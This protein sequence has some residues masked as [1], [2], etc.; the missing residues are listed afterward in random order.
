MIQK[1]IISIIIP[2]FNGEKYIKGCLDSVLRSGFKNF[3]IIIIND[4]STD[5]SGEILKEY[6]NHPKIK[7][8]SFQ[9]NFGPAKARNSGAEKAKGKYLIFLDID[10]EI[11]T[12]CLRAVVRAFEQN[13]KMGAL[14]AKII[15]GRGNKI[16]AAGHF[17]TFF[18]FPYEIGGGEKEKNHNE[19]RLI[20]GARSAAMAVRKK[21]F[22]K[23]GGF[24]EDYFI[25]GEDTD[26]SWRVW[27]VGYQIYYLPQAKVYHFT[28]SSLTPKTEYRI[29]Y[30]GSKN[31]TLNLLK[32][33]PLTLLIWIL[34]LHVLAWTLL[35]LKLLFQGRSKL[36]VSIYQGVWWNLV[37][38]QETVK[39]RRRV[40]SERSPHP[41]YPK[42]I[43]GRP[44][45]KQLFLKGRRWFKDV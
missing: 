25:Y 30:Q 29:F 12:D 18:G 41:L 39:K 26:L 11:E 36:A 15:K 16:D 43:F 10:T 42:I 40:L 27:L 44:G 32:N 4:G 38:F 20:L 7:I 22:R 24:D 9:N 33:A 1:P 17:L 21:V 14:Q 5:K 35:S 23:I 6:Q 8:C 37:N 19:R 34:P 2:C 28:K 3:E 13:P 45:L 31:Q